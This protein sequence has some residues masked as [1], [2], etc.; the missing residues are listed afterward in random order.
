MILSR[1]IFLISLLAA[2]GFAFSLLVL[3]YL[4]VPNMD[5]VGISRGDILMAIFGDVTKV[6]MEIIT[7]VMICTLAASLMTR[8][9]V[10]QERQ[11]LLLRRQLFKAYGNLQYSQ[12]E[13]R[14]L[15]DTL[16]QLARVTG[17][18]ATRLKHMEN[19]ATG[20]TVLAPSDYDIGAV[21]GTGNVLPIRAALETVS[22]ELSQASSS[23][24]EVMPSAHSLRPL[25]ERAEVAGQALVELDRVV[26]KLNRLTINAVLE[27]CRLGDQGSGI[28]QLVGELKLLGKETA[29]QTATIGEQIRQM[30]TALSSANSPLASLLS[31]A[32]ASL[33]HL[34]EASELIDEQWDTIITALPDTEREAS[35]LA[36]E[37]AEVAQQASELEKKIATLAVHTS[38]REAA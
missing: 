16:K 14:Q 21:N 26:G 2:L 8:A 32:D 13:L 23:L 11:Q 19:G 17:D 9:I 27:A 35:A 18:M 10:G 15:K 5:G 24:R 12:D 3:V 38:L 1:K 34:N 37:V 30:R 29:E 20:T 4:T 36:R 6:T 31:D 25:F 33:R 7:L 22:D 28:A